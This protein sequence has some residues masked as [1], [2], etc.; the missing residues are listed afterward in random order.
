MFK[1]VIALLFIVVIFFSNIVFA[2]QSTSIDD[3]MNAKY[4]QQVSKS[5][6]NSGTSVISDEKIN[7]SIKNN[8]SAF[9]F[10]KTDSTAS[11]T[12][13]NFGKRTYT[14]AFKII[15]EM[16]RLSFPICLLGILAGAMVYY[17]FGPRNLPRKKYDQLL[18]IGFSSVFVIIQIATAVLYYL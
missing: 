10:N 6:N 12:I 9:D 16:R 8:E 13:E 14:L 3:K 2:S 18:M 11:D 15:N 5:E 7:Q 4:D 17:I 1:K